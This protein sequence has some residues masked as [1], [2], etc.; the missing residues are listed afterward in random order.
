MNTK[1]V[2]F[3]AFC[4][5]CKHFKVPTTMDPCNECLHVPARD[6]YSHRPINY[7][8]DLDRMG[9]RNHGRFVDRER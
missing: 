6:D 4:P 8:A 7:V 2:R 3:D 9:A 5:H 1:I